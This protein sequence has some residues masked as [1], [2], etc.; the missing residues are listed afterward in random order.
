MNG[1]DNGPLRGVKATTREGG[2]RVPFLVRYPGKLPAGKVYD[3]PVIQ[4]D[5]T[6]TVLA[7]AGVT[8]ADAKFDGVNLLP[9]LA[10]DKADAPHPVLYWRF[11][12][13]IAVRAGDW[14][15][16][17]AVDGGGRA[18]GG[19][20]AARRQK[21]SVEGAQLFNLKD[22]VGEQTDLAG[23][24]PEKV[25][26]LAGLWEKWNAELAPPAWGPP[27]RPKANAN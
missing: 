3:Q 25:K 17:K 11:G 18:G 10:G 27:A 20:A 23:K 26:E 6:P 8:A 5:V 24:N 21:A 13:Q 15:L 19:G 4:L 14:K 7:A 16:V 12:G 9:Y 22:D 1:S 2:V